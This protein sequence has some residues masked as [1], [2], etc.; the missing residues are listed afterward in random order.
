MWE[1]ILD[2][3]VISLLA[4]T[5]YFCWRLNERISELKNSKR[6][7]VELVRTFDDA[8]KKTNTSVTELRT[9]SKNSTQELQNYIKKA[10]E[11]IGDLSFLT[12]SASEISDRL[13]TNIKAVRANDLSKAATPANLNSVI[14]SIEN[15]GEPAK[16]G[17][18]K[19]IKASFAKTRDEFMAAIKNGKR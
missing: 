14:Q 19:A 17:G 15:I 10:S 9:M 13:E 4:V 8:I 11:L 7:L 2:T 6:D 18:I 5:I 12:D 3:V 1:I 16:N